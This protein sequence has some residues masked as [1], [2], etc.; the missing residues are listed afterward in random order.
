MRGIEAGVLPTAL[1]YGIGVLT[2]SPLNSGWLIGRFRRGEQIEITDFRRVIAHK[3]DLNLP[4]NQA[5][6]DA[7]E[8]LLSVAEEVGVPVTHLALAFA[9]THPAVSSVILGPRTIEHLTDQLAAADLT[10]DD[11]TLDRIDEIVPPGVNLN[12]TDTDYHPPALNDATQRRRPINQ[13]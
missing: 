6:L 4:G 8:Q 1:K 9:A 10:L 13:R 12:P 7:V 11:Q 2:W 5:K 3:F